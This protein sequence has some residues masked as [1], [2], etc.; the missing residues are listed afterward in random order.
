MISKSTLKRK[1]EE[2]EHAQ[3]GVVDERARTIRTAAPAPVA[4][5]SPIKAA[6]D[7][8]TIAS[9][10]VEA[11]PFRREIQRYLTPI[12][13][14]WNGARANLIDIGRELNRAKAALGHGKFEKM[15]RSYLPFSKQIAH[16]LRTVAEAIDTGK[17]AEEV[18]PPSYSVAYQLVSID[19]AA[20]ALAKERDLIRPDVTRAALLK[21]KADWK[22]M[23]EQGPQSDEEREI[24]ELG[25]ERERLLARLARIDARIDD[26]RSG[27]SRAA[28]GGAVIEGT[29]TVLDV[30]D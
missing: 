13:N 18:L 16:Q 19:P 15:C 27:R 23:Q 6:R 1:A 2:R 20:L 4:V 21:F 28:D 7:V 24:A 14:L 11:D 8:A 25:E 3:A 29:A 26:L 9:G 22:R 5:P 30:A 12:A 10:E 17:W